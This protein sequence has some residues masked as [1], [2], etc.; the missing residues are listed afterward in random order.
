M[1]A[2]IIIALLIAILSIGYNYVY[3]HTISV[4][5]IVAWGIDMF[6]IGGVPGSRPAVRLFFASLSAPSNWTSS[7]LK[8]DV[9][10]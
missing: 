5:V 3:I 8:A 10:T 1:I 7:T 4:S 6:S 9:R 2:I